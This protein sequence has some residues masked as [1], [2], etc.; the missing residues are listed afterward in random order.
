MSGGEG[1]ATYQLASNEPDNDTCDRL[2]VISL[3]FRQSIS[4]GWVVER[5]STSVAFWF[6]LVGGIMSR[7][8]EVHDENGHLASLGQ[9]LLFSY[10][11]EATGRSFQAL[12][13]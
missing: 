3:Q 8:H 4:I 6:S 2:P 1:S 11:A 7:A 12:D 10:T 5:L 9:T 13:T